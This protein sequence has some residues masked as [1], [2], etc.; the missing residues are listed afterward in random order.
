MG[1]QGVFLTFPQLTKYAT[2]D[3]FSKHRYQEGLWKSQGRIYG[4]IVYSTDEKLGL[5][6]KGRF[7]PAMLLEASR[8][9]VTELDRG[10]MLDG[11]RT[12]FNLCK[13]YK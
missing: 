2:K 4:I 13:G 9:P 1:F 6:T 8:P 7:Q 3:L 5:V 10:H 11:Q 12:V